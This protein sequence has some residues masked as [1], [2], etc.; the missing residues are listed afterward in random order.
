MTRTP[1]NCGVKSL[2]NR[3]NILLNILFLS[4]RLLLDRHK[5]KKYILARTACLGTEVINILKKDLKVFNMQK[6]RIDLL[7]H[8]IAGEQI[9]IKFKHIKSIKNIQIGVIVLH[10]MD[11]Q[12]PNRSSPEMLIMDTFSELTDQRFHHVKSN[13]TFYANYSD[14]KP[15]CIASAEIAC[16]GLIAEGQIYAEYFKF[17]EKFNTLWP[18]TPIF[19]I[20]FP[21]KFDSR[22]EFKLRAKIIEAAITK[23]TDDFSNLRLIKIN[24]S[25]IE[26]SPENESFIYHYSERV[27]GYLAGKISSDPSCQIIGID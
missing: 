11:N 26:N 7:N 18:N 19:F 5:S 17:F 3:F 10:Q 12:W 1:Y 14:V 8:Q 25:K 4:K 9:N 20:S 27:S 24:E 23:C 15:Q 21:T 6:N 13:K 16:Y 22:L 2:K